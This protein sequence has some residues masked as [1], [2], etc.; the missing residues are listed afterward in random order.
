MVERMGRM[1]AE[2]A[3][4]LAMLSAGASPPPP[5]ATGSIPRGPTPALVDS[6]RPIAGGPPPLADASLAHLSAMAGAAPFSLPSV[7]SPSRLAPSVVWPPLTESKPA[8]RVPPAGFVPSARPGITPAVVPTADPALLAAAQRAFAVAH[9]LPAHLVTEALITGSHEGVL[10]WAARDRSGPRSPAGHPSLSEA[11]VPP[12][13][14]VGF[15]GMDPVALL[16]DSSSDLSM[17]K[18]SGARGAA[19]Y[20][21][22]RRMFTRSPGLYAALVRRNMLTSQERY[23]GDADAEDASAWEFVHDNFQLGTQ[24]TLSYCALGFAH[25]F[26]MCR[27]RRWELVEDATARM[28]VATE[29]A[30]MDN[31]QWQ[32]AWP[33]TFMR[34]PQWTRLQPKPSGNDP[35]S[36]QFGLLADP[37]WTAVVLAYLKDAAAV[38]ELR[39]RA[40]QPRK[41]PKGGDQKGGGK[42]KGGDA[43]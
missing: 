1:E 3:R 30:A 32:I 42:G 26:D 15:G 35:L 36:P 16:A 27:A 43:A 40:G 13:G 20:E 33:L 37:S 19:G 7:S 21:M 18:V 29:Q 5:S 2:Q 10:G 9:S 25:I 38:Q 8:S 14:A 28:L 23:P 41:P 39:R 24:R 4:L 17:A 11:A 22:L 6:T 31:S 12:S 34:E